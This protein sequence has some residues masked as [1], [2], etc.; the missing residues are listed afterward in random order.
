MARRLRA[1]FTPLARTLATA[2]RLRGTPQATLLM[3]HDVLPA[4]REPHHI[5]VAAF[6][7]QMER[8]ASGPFQVVSL[9]HALTGA[10]TGAGRLHPAVAITF[11]DARDN[12]VA[13]ALPVLE[14]LG[15]PCT[16]FTPSGLLGR[17]GHVSAAELAAM[18]GRGVDI[19]AHSRSHLRLAEQDDVTVDDEVRGSKQDLEDLLGQPVR[20]FAYPY[21]SV[22]GRVRDAVVAAGFDAAVLSE[23]G[24]VTGSTDRHLLYRSAPDSRMTLAW[25]D[26]MA[27]GGDD[28]LRLPQAARRPLRWVVRAWERDGAQARSSTLR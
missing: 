26:V 17:P 2:S 5:S 24:R 7:A 21:G 23:P 9:E 13:N 15:L 10:R 3:Y 1:G 22:D 11:D 18:A 25:F 19:G 12:F 14:R 8:L 20:Y 16:M 4:A 6:T 28:V 27:L